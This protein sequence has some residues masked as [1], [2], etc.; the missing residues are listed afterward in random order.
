MKDDPVFDPDTVDRFYDRQRREILARVEPAAGATAA[1]LR[2]GR[3]LRLAGLA[4]AAVVVI[5]AGLLLRPPPAVA[6]PELAA[7]DTAADAGEFPFDAYGSWPPAAEIETEE[8]GAA[9]VGWLFDLAGHDGLSRTSLEV[10]SSG[11]DFLAAYGTWEEV[12]DDV[13]AHDAT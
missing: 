9:S 4:A 12:A 8:Q 10:D 11:T 6:P 1:G 3:G 2:D 5:G 7:G 13:V